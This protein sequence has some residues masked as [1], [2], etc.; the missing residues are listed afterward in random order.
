[1]LENH[2]GSDAGKQKTKDIHVTRAIKHDGSA[3]KLKWKSTTRKHTDS[4]DGRPIGAEPHW[5]RA[6][7]S[8]TPTNQQQEQQQNAAK[9]I[10][11][12]RPGAS[13]SRR[14]AW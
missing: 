8:T 9:M 4:V 1:M 12:R 11:T 2:S 5:V 14:W 7:T 3:V 10:S 6:H 13:K